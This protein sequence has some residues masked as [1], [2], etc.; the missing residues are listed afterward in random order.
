MLVE[1]RVNRAIKQRDFGGLKRRGDLRSLWKG[2]SVLENRVNRAIKQRDFGG[3][4]ER[5]P[6][7]SVERWNT[8]GKEGERTMKQRDFGGLKRRG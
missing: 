5:R 7:K 1:N 8:C 4:K 3:R 6:P 2:G